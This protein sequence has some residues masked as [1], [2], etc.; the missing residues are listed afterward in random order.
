MKSYYKDFTVLV[1]TEGNDDWQLYIYQTQEGE[2]EILILHQEYPNKLTK[3]EV[4]SIGLSYVEA[5]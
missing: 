2:L 3:E 1:E 5:M 4:I